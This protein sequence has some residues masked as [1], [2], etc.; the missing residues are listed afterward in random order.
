M[1]QNQIPLTLNVVVLGANGGI[2]KHAV[3]SALNAG[4]QVTAILRTP[5]NLEI[6]H[7]NLQIV[8]GDIMK[9]E[10]LDKY[11]ENKDVVISAIGKNSLKKTTLYSQGNKNLIDAMK[12]AGVNRAF[13]ISASGLEVNPT[14]S[15]LVKF[16]TKFILQTL[17]RNMYADL[18]KMEKIVKESNIN[19]TIM[20]PPKLLNSPETGKYRTA[21]D[22]YLNNGLEISRADVAHFIVNNLTNKAIIKKTVEIAY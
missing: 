17:L 2:G 1:E 13:F 15:L 7:P 8:Q 12:R 19:W 16:L 14:H 18:W 5:A 21:I 22:H 10:T 11:L 6:T 4:H 9:P 20:R 3:L